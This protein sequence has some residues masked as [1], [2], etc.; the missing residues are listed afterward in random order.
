MLINYFREIGSRRFIIMIIGN[1]FLGIGIG[2]FKY[3]GMGNDPFSAMVMALSDVV[4]IS[5]PV[6]LIIFN[7]FVFVIEFAFGRH[8]IGAGTIVNSCLIGY[9]AS[10]FYDLCG[11]LFGTP[12]ALWQRLITVCV[13]V[14]VTSFGVALYQTPDVGI[15]PYDSLSLIMTERWPKISYF[16]H[17]MSNDAVAALVCYLAGGIVGLGTLLT[18]IGLGPFV[19][20]FTE[21][22]AK[23]LVGPI[24]VHT[25]K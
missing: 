23:K 17:R 3:S 6:F 25:H 14:I 20:F 7:L 9:V 22:F 11:S 8:F 1:I 4:G 10:F 19:H 2:I 21:H 18:A 15:A 24:E 5:Y 12:G 16:W 13:G